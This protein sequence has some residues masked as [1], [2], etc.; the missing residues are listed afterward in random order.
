M[1]NLRP[2]LIRWRAIG[3]AVFAPLLLSFILLAPTFPPGL[4]PVV[5]YA[6][7]LGILFASWSLVKGD[8]IWARGVLF[9]EGLLFFASLFLQTISGTVIQTLPLLLL[10]YVMILFAAEALELVRRHSVTFSKEVQALPA[11]Q[12]IPMLNRATQYSYQKL[13]RLAVLL[14]ICYFLSVVAISLGDLFLST[15]PMLSDISFYM[16][17]VSI[18][19]VLL[20]ILR[21]K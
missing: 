12:S 3:F 8:W 6:S 16:V 2:T 10:V 7:G 14:G 21:E 11:S 5:V 13:A 9:F 17:A 18:S 20:L 4:F 19:L 1:K 15:L